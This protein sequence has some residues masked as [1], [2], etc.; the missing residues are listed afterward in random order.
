[1]CFEGASCSGSG[2]QGVTDAG[3]NAGASMPAAVDVSRAYPGTTFSTEPFTSSSGVVGTAGT[4]VATTLAPSMW[5]RASFAMTGGG[6]GDLAKQLGPTAVKA[7]LAAFQGQNAGKTFNDQLAG[8]IRR[9]NSQTYG[10]SQA[11]P[12]GLSG[13]RGAVDPAATIAASGRPAPAIGTGGGGTGS[14]TG[15]TPAAPA[16]PRG[17]Q[18]GAVTLGE[19]PNMYA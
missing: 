5:D 10:A 2:A 9:N 18:T 7:G 14:V 15:G 19:R 1:M 8:L 17:G 16:A 4:S 6:G 13:S 3:M 12:P 11:A